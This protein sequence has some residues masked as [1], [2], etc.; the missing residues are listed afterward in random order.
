MTDAPAAEAVAAPDAEP[1]PLTVAPAPEIPLTA[2]DP[3]DDP[4]AAAMEAP[5]AEAVPAPDE[6]PEA[7]AVAAPVPLA[8]AA[9]DA[10]PTPSVVP[11][12]ATLISTQA[13]CA[14]PVSV[15]L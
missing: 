10:D 13:T 12:V 4:A 14:R 11:L 8:V 2:E 1:A 5:D 9:P 6:A 15:Q 3:A 7:A